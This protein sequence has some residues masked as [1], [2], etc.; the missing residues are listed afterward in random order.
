MCDSFVDPAVRRSENKIRIGKRKKNR[1]L[2]ASESFFF[3]SKD[4]LRTF[5]CEG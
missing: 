3:S 1:K 2:P 5:A 4:E